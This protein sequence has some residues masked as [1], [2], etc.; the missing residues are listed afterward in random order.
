MEDFMDA[1]ED[2]QK[3]LKRAVKELSKSKNIDE[4]IKLSELIKN[5]S[6]AVGVYF[7]FASDMMINEMGFP[8]MDDDDDDDDDLEH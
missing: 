7:S 6:S 1:V 2:M 4:R 3:E 5:L 8:E